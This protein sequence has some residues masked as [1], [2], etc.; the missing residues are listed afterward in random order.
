MCFGVHTAIYSAAGV[1]ASTKGRVDICGIE[2]GAV[3]AA[4]NH[5]LA[6]EVQGL[7]QSGGPRVAVDLLHLGHVA[8][9]DTRVIAGLTKTSKHPAGLEQV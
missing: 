2:K 5:V 9:I 8:A 1:E 7:Y 3:G 4:G 6:G